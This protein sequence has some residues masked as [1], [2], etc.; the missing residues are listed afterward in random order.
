MFVSLWKLKSF[1]IQ[2]NRNE[3]IKNV[4]CRAVFKFF[5]Q[6]KFSIRMF[7]FVIAPILNVHFKFDDVFDSLLLLKRGIICNI[8]LRPLYPST[9]CIQ[10]PP[11]EN[12]LKK[13]LYKPLISFVAISN[14]FLNFI[15]IEV[16]VSSNTE[17]RFAR[18][19]FPCIYDCTKLF[20]VH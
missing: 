16:R 1:K 17:P 8:L 18:I 6:I 15:T 12:A 10:W 7:H 9:N 11:F 20:I 4:S 2:I 14:V 19:I 13:T 5:G 3:N